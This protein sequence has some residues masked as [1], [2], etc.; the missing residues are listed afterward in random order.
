MCTASFKKRAPFLYTR[1]YTPLK[2]ESRLSFSFCTPV[3]ISSICI[4]FHRNP[5][6]NMTN[7]Y[8]Y[9]AYIFFF[10]PFLSRYFLFILYILY[11]SY[12]VRHLLLVD[13]LQQSDYFH[14][15]AISCKRL[16]KFP[17]S[18]YTFCVTLIFRYSEV[19]LHN[20]Y[21]SSCIYQG[22]FYYAD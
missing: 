11:N 20:T 18:F 22:G 15:Y 4:I 16:F 3:C 21:G 19:L 10:F 9:F 13:F 17:S 14:F 2:K 5:F 8:R 1:V 7:E 6:V 12:K